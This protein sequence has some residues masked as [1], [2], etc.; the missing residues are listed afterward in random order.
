MRKVPTA[1][2]MEKKRSG[3][4]GEPVTS[5]QRLLA[6][7][8]ARRHYSSFCS[9]GAGAIRRR[10]THFAVSL[11]ATC[12]LLRLIECVWC[13]FELSGFL[14]VCVRCVLWSAF[15]SAVSLC[16]VCVC[17]SFC[18]LGPNAQCPS[19]RVTDRVHAKTSRVPQSPPRP[20]V[21]PLPATP[22]PLITPL[23]TLLHPSHPSFFARLYLANYKWQYLAMI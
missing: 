19:L 18:C 8:A 10:C 23:P 5:S 16:L 21:V 17:N 20:H 11:P 22:L 9:G 12:T 15:Y 3:E 14:P 6:A 13:Q 7:A 1:D 4:W 2:W